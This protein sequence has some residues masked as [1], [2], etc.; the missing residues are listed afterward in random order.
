[1]KA[2]ARSC[3]NAFLRLGGDRRGNFGLIFGLVAIPVIVGVGCSLDF[4]R[5]YGIRLKMQSDLDSALIAAVKNVDTLDETHIKQRVKDWFNAQ[6]SEQ[7]VAYTLSSDAITV[8]KGSR[9]ITAN[10]S[11]TIPTT[12]LGI[13]NVT[14]LPVAVQTSVAGPATSYLNV[15]IVLDKS[16]SMMLPAT[17]AGQASMQTYSESACVFAC[18]TA[19]G[20]SK[21]YNGVVYKNNFALSRAMGVKLRTD[22]AVD[23]AANVISQIASADPKQTYIKVGLYAIGGTGTQVLAPT[24]STATAL[25]ALNND[26]NGLTSATSQSTSAFDVSLPQLASFVG[27]A[28]DGSS[29]AKPLKLVLMMT[30]GVQSTRPWVT[31]DDNSNTYVTPLNP[32]WCKSMVTAGATVGVLYTEYLPMTWDWGYNRT[33]ALKLKNSAFAS[34]WGGVRDTASASNI[35]S[36]N[37][38]PYALKA[39][40]SSSDMYISAADASAIQAGLGKLFQQYLGSVRLTQ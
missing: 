1:L 29:A 18:H 21:P 25:S 12:L 11:A 10:A 34:K 16:A 31:A 39:C 22:I 37:Y 3:V 28:G 38:I 4:A 27:T 35:T 5:S 32:A 19:E 24:S 2:F 30:D 40:A 13:L 20:D 33:L 15:Y 17:A 14:Q 9:V 26:N 7:G 36:L 6:S 8:S 23:A